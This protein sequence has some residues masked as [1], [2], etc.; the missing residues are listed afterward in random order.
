MTTFSSTNHEALENEEYDV[1]A[2]RLELTGPP[3][4]PPPPPP[5]RAAVNQA[6]EDAYAAAAASSGFENAY[7]N[8]LCAELSN[9]IQFN[10]NSIKRDQVGFEL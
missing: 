6:P 4:P 1:G 2:E 9:I 8:A 3:P 10:D 5:P 7:V